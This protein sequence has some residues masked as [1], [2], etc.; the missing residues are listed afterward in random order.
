VVDWGSVPAWIGAVGSLL[1]AAVI[2]GGL[3]HELRM[4]READARAEAERYD[5]AARPARLVSVG[6]GIAKSRGGKVSVRNDGDAPIRALAYTV[7]TTTPEGEVKRIPARSSKPRQPF[8]GAHSE[9]RA[10]IFVPEVVDPKTSYLEVEF[11]DRNGLRWA[12]TDR[13]ELR[14]LLLEPEPD[15]D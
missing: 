13:D 12:L 1:V 5:A 6:G 10:D 4:R 14:Q 11:T 2:G 7:V 15:S 8:V 3:L 9:V